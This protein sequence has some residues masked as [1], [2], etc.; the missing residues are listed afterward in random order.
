MQTM[1]PIVQI[2]INNQ[3]IIIV[4][5]DNMR[6]NRTLIPL[7][8]MIIIRIIINI[9]QKTKNMSV[10]LVHLKDFS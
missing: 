6:I 7:I 4:R 1:K 8:I 3:I 9:L 10:E 5:T 2:I